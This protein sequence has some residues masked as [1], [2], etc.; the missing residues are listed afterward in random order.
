MATK[1]DFGSNVQNMYLLWILI[2]IIYLSKK[3]YYNNLYIV[4][5]KI[6]V[7]LYS[8]WLMVFV[9]YFLTPCLWFEVSRERSRKVSLVIFKSQGNIILFDDRIFY[10]FLIFT[11]W[12][13]YE[14]TKNNTSIYIVSTPKKKIPIVDLAT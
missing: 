6:L 10:I 3:L 13:I 5:S 8:G 14:G 11:S 9:Y 12:L 4:K 2:I 1:S 7:I